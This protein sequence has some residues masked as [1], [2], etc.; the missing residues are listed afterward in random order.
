VRLRTGIRSIPMTPNPAGGG[1]RGAAA[2]RWR[3]AITA[4]WAFLVLATASSGHAYAQECPRPDPVVQKAK[5]QECRAAGD[6]W[7]R[8]GAIAHLCG[9]YSCVPRTKDG[10][11]PCRSRIDCEYLC[12]H[13]RGAVIGTEV[14]GECAAVRTSFGCTTQVDHGR[15]VGTVCLD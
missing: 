4:G 11:K 12:V 14:T 7:G 8:F 13:R 5:E 10:G 2:P 9:I 6:E 3:A 15:V 1:R